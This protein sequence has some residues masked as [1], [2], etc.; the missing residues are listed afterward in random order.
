MNKY[1]KIASIVYSFIILFS[2]CEQQSQIVSSVQIDNSNDPL[3]PLAIGNIWYYKD[4]YDTDS[5]TITQYYNIS[6][7][8]TLYYQNLC[9][10]LL[11]DSRDTLNPKEVYTNSGDSTLYPNWTTDGFYTHPKYIKPINRDT[12]EFTLQYG[13]MSN[14][15]KAIKIQKPV[16]VF[17]GYFQKCVLFQNNPFRDDEYEIV[18]PGVGM[19]E[20]INLYDY[21]PRKTYLI[22]YRLN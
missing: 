13:C 2:G 4:S 21:P 5:G 22:S 7:K 18:C 3:I 8:D 9:W 6:I 10:Y 15:R 14:S 11:Y 16:I 19:I 12:V 17:A 1:L 20:K